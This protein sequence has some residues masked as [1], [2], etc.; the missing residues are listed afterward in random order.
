MARVGCPATYTK[1]EEIE[2]LIEHYFN[3]CKGPIIDK[4]GNVLKDG[5]G[6]IIMEYI[7]PITITGLCLAL[8]FTSRDALIDYGHREIFAD[9]IARAK[10]QCHHYT[11]TRLYDKEGCNGA[12]FSLSNN[13]GWIDKQ[14]ITTNISVEL[15][16]KDLQLEIAN[17]LQKRQ[18]I[19]A[20]PV[21]YQ[22]L[23]DEAKALNP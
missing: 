11:E 22:V 16:S 13:F 2:G 8:G 12:K 6:D 5:N 10:L 1:I 9:T 20:I 21:D 17:L 3:S 19:E 4:E 15:T 7:K 18:L 14:E 23:E